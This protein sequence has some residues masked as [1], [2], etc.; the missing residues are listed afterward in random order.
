MQ[1]QNLTCLDAAPKELLIAAVVASIPLVFDTI[2]DIEPKP[3]DEGKTD[4]FRW[5]WAVF[6]IPTDALGGYV[7]ARMAANQGQH[8]PKPA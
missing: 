4:Y 5:A 3:D 8:H 6:L 7:F 2:R 1:G